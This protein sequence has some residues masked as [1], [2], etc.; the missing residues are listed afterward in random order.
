MKIA[1][2]ERKRSTEGVNLSGGRKI[3]NCNRIALRR[4]P[5]NNRVPKGQ[6]KKATSSQISQVKGQ[7][8]CFHCERCVKVYFY[9]S[10]HT[11][12]LSLRGLKEEKTVRRSDFMWIKSLCFLFS[13][14]I[15]FAVDNIVLFFIPRKIGR[16]RFIQWTKFLTW[17]R[18]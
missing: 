16:R 7:R 15:D 5:R 6:A 8:N 1:E 13:V 18:R 14:G 4:I 10:T 17:W 2:D 11:C 9:I 3:G 12:P